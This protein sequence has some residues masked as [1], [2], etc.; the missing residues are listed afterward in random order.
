M[1][2]TDDIDLHLISPTSG[3]GLDGLIPTAENVTLGGLSVTSAEFRDFRDF[4]DFRQ[5]GPG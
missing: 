3:V 1:V 2:S 4:R 5:H